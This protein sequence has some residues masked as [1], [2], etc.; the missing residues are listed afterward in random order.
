MNMVPN[1]MKKRFRNHKKTGH[2]DMC[3]PARRRS[4]DAVDVEFNKSGLTFPT[5]PIVTVYS[6]YRN[7]A[8]PA[9]EFFAAPFACQ[10]VLAG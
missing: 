9:E 1:F 10:L 5:L 2:R 8:A 3:Q 4:E 7:F 6:R